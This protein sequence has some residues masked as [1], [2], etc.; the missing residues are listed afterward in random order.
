MLCGVHTNADDA[1]KTQCKR[2]LFFGDVNTMSA[3]ECRCRLKA[4]LLRGLDVNAS[5]PVGREKHMQVMP[6]LISPLPSEEELDRA[7]A[8][9]G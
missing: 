1:P 5:D 6:R 4:W 2:Q 9:L 8:A 7:A 3:E